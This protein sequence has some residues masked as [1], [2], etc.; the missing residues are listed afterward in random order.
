MRLLIVIAAILAPFTAIAEGISERPGWRVI[1]TNLGYQPLIDAVKSATEAHEM[2]VVTEA[3]PTEAA[4][5]L[6]T[7]LPGNRVIGVFHPKYAIRIL[8]LSTAAMIEAP[9]R[10]YVTEDA[11][12]TAVL[13]WKTPSFVF[14]PYLDEAGP[15]LAA[16]GTELD[17]VF[18]AI[19][20]DATETP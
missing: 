8:P 14:A 19:A 16:I 4:A 9:I 20:A 7:V 6:G 13:S 2:R 12:G 10:F 5:K 18:D 11:D 1:D 3:G 15:D 17:S